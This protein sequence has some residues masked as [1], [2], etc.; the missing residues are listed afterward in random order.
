MSKLQPVRGSR[1]IWGEEARRQTYVVEKFSEISKNFGFE[2]I[3]TPIFEFT[4][5]F[6]K[7]LGETSD[8][9]SK[10][11]YTFVDRGGDELTLRPEYT[12]GIAR[13]YLS[14]GMQQKGVLKFYAH[15]PMFRYERPQK[16]RYRQFHQLDAEI[17]GAPE[18]AADIEMIA[19]GHQLLSALG[20]AGKTTLNLNSLGDMDSRTAYREA[21]VDYLSERKDKLS[22][23]SLDRL[24]RNPMRVLDSKDQGDQ[25]VVAN[26]PKLN[27]YLNDASREFFAEVQAGLKNLGIPFV[28]NDHLVR[29]LDY[30]CHTT[31]EFITEELGAQGAVIAGGRYD[32]LIG[33]MGGPETPGTGWAAGIDRLAM[34]IENFPEARRGIVL[35]PVS[36]EAEKMAA[37]LCHD[38][39]KGGL[40]ADMAFRG[41]MKKRLQRANRQNARWAV[42]L[43][44]DEMAEAAVTV[45]DLD[46][47]DQETIKQDALLAFFSKASGD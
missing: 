41:N 39:R 26:A 21:L 25:E 40:G 32:G 24:E 46:S 6:Q 44:D 9:V 19:L 34:M 38:L 33:M 28:L 20:I 31:Y 37:R 4:S 29:G 35:V 23:E 13:A 14:E 11:M 30:Y 17:I 1:D 10:E 15:G 42:I 5:V 47:G 22:P 45:R 36:E 8:V 18:A 16:G 12:A 2:E 43:G 27:D 7:T 3:S